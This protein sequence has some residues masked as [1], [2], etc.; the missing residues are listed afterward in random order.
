MIRDWKELVRDGVV[1]QPGYY[2]NEGRVTFTP[3][4]EETVKLVILHRANIRADFS[5]SKD[6]DKIITLP[7]LP[8]LKFDKIKFSSANISADQICRNMRIYKGNGIRTNLI[9]KDYDFIPARALLRY[10]QERERED[11]PRVRIPPA[12]SMT[13]L[14]ITVSNTKPVNTT[15]KQSLSKRL[16]SPRGEKEK[17][18]VTREAREVL[19]GDREVEVIG[20]LRVA[21]ERQ[22]ARAKAQPRPVEKAKAAI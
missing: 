12:E 13:G 8:G 14:E 2:T 10:E 4:Q 15:P 19:R 20:E 9:T 7:P 3:P 16:G 5:T 17:G 6:K 1:R 18:E 22:D 21:K 11:G